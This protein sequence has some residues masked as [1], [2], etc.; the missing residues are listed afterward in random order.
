M[1]T[2]LLSRNIILSRVDANTALPAWVGNHVRGCRHCRAVYD[3]AR[4]LATQLSSTG[5]TARGGVP[6][7]LHA[8]VMSAVRAQARPEVM[9]NR[10]R[11]GWAAAIGTACL[12]IAGVVL[13]R[14]PPVPARVATNSIATPAEL[15]THANLPTAAQVDQ[16]AKT[17]DAPLEQETKLVLL[18]ATAAINTLAR[19]FLPE[20]LLAASTEPARR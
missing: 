2:C 16:W 4:T 3:S 14:Q 18:D 7:F 6:P 12:L 8:K 10:W 11:Y 9:T 5:I 20:D 19:G 1:I 13:L 15:A 17:L